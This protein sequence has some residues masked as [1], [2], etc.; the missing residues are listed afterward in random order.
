MMVDIDAETAVE[1]A[2]HLKSEQIEAMMNGDDF[3]PILPEFEVY[4]THLSHGRTP[5]QVKTDVLGVK[6][7]PRDAKLLGEIFTC[8]ASTTTNAQ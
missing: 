1:L 4:R 3:I 8:M 5:S 6:C 2:L 7:V